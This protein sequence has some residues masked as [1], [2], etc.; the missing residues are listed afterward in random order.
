MAQL[1][2]GTDLGWEERRTEAERWRPHGKHPILS[3]SDCPRSCKKSEPSRK[4][5]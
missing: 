1:A 5:G 2:A 3:S 4:D